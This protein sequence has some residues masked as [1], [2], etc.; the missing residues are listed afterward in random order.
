MGGLGQGRPER[1][2][3]D[4][5]LVFGQALFEAQTGGKHQDAKPM[6]GFKGASVLEIVDDFDGDTYRA[7]YTVKFEGVIYILHA[8]QKKSKKGKETPQHDLNLI[9]SRL[10]LAEQHY[11]ENYKERKTG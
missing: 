6:K 10:K 4:V 2:P 7:V 3:S 5:K 8:F 9:K 1:M 11:E